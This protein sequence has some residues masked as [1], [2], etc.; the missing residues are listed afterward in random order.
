MNRKSNRQMY[1]KTDR[2]VGKQQILESTFY[3]KVKD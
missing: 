3:K 2:K 1:R